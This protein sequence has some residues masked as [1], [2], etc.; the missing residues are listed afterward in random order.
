M[1]DIRRKYAETGNEAVLETLE[2]H[3]G[4]L[5]DVDHH[6]RLELNAARREVSTERR[7]SDDRLETVMRRFDSL[8]AAMEDLGSQVLA[9]VKHSVAQTHQIAELV[10]AFNRFAS[11][12]G[13]HV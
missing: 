1:S 10:E 6:M 5:L 7:L 9:L 12:G 3:H 2:E 11:N 8:E 4:R 13:S